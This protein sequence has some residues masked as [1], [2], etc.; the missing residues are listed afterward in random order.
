MTTTKELR[1]A[2]KPIKVK[3]TNPLHPSNLLSTGLT[4]LNLAC[5]GKAF[6]GIP[7]GK[8][9]LLVGDSASGKTF[10]SR[11]ILAEATLNK[12]FNNYRLIYDDAEDGAMMD[13]DKFFGSDLA[14]RLEPPNGTK[15]EPKYS[16]TLEEFYY[17]VDDAVKTNQP[18]IYVLDSMD[19]L[20]PEDDLKKFQKKKNARLKG[21]EETGSYGT[22]KAKA[23]SSGLRIA[24]NAIKE[25]GSILI[26]IAQ[27]RDKL[28]FGFEKKTRSGGHALRFY[29]DLELWFSIRNKI[30]RPVHGKDRQIGTMLRIQIKK[31]RM[32]GRE[33]TTDVPFYPSHGFDDT[34]AMVNFLVDEGY[35]KV[36]NKRINAHDWELVLSEDKLV[37][38]I[39]QEGMQGDL[40]ML[41]STVWDEIEAA[42]T[43]QRTN[44][45]TKVEE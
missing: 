1:K 29:A 14:E 25:N 35:W 28:D 18:F 32:T 16:S 12:H 39:E 42:T 31:N 11:A 24:R 37:R 22:A 41:V 43:V 33:A 21:K 38:H 26:I 8:Y 15:A 9:V 17:H 34:G 45:Y 27:T 19:S 5:S 7:K 3:S 10:L 20:S 6:A 4:T 13:V 44:R 23:N 40:R 2:L 36:S 30:K